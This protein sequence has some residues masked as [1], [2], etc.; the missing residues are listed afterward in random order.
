MKTL[1]G[2]NEA[3]IM[4]NVRIGYCNEKAKVTNYR[5]C[6]DMWDDV[7]EFLYLRVGENSIAKLNTE[8]IDVLDIPSRELWKRAVE[9]TKKEAVVLNFFGMTIITNKQ[10]HLGAACVLNKEK[11]KEL[12][13][14]WGVTEVALL[15]SSTHEVIVM[16][17]DGTITLEELSNMVREIN[18]TEVDEVDQLSDHAISLDVMEM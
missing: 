14:E 6:N 16:P 18:G 4:E 8:N 7:D 11:L 13:N 3:E 17:Y 15:P 12:A 2:M 10:K 9:N 1:V 5:R